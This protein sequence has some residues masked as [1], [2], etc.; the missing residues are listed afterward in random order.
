[1]VPP[2]LTTEFHVGK[3]YFESTGMLDSPA[4]K[5][6]YVYKEPGKGRGDDTERMIE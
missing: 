3:E 6:K 4:R 1:M 5:T 2:P